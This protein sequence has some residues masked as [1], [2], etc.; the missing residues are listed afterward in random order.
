MEKYEII[1]DAMG[2]DHAPGEIIK[3]AAQACRESETLTCVFVGE[4]N[5]IIPLIRAEKIPE[6]R[7]RIVHAS[8][9]IEMDDPPKEAVNEK[10]DASINVATRLIR[11]HKGDALVSAGSTGATVLA[12]AKTIP[13]LPGI[14]RGVLAAVFP[15]AKSQRSDTGVTIMLDVGAT[16][17][18]TVNQLISFA[19]MGIHYAKTILAIEK[20]RVGLLNIGEEDTKGHEVLVETN[21]TLREMKDFNFIGN[22]EGKD[23]MRG[24]ADVIITEG[25]TGNIVLKGMEGMAEMAMQTGKRIWKKNLL[26]KL[27]IIMLAPVLKKLKKRLDYSE[28][29]G[30]PILGFEKLVIKAH[31]RSNAKAIKNAILLAEKSASADLPDQMEKSIKSFYLRMFEEKETPQEP[32]QKPDQE[33]PEEHQNQKPEEE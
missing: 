13:R 17:H 21:K 32:E 5:R 26:S 8:E 28:Y 20:P 19:I 33:A 16:L 18:C 12:C 25:L 9:V 1:I 23:I 24:I 22:V 30:A 31:G 11:D 6:E 4:S 7:Y 27:G 2:G 15:A 10:I 14:E 29:G 3:G